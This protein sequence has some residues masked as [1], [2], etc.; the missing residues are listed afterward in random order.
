MKE[1]I[2]KLIKTIHDVAPKDR[3]VK[4]MNVCGSHEHTIT[5]SGMRSLM[6]ETIEL[7]PGPGCP[8]CVCSESDIVNAINL[9]KRED[10]ILATYGDMLRVPTQI[11]S[12]RSSGGNYKM[13][14]APH[15]VLKIAKENPEKNVVFF[16][17][18]FETT[19][20][21]TAALIEM[22]LPKNV[23][24]LTSQKLTP[25]IME[26]L[27]KDSEVGV[28]AF[29]APGHVSAIVG[30]DAWKIFPKK[31]GIPTV[32]AGFEPENLLLAIL[33]ILLQIKEGKA[34]LENVY[35]GVVK[36][37]GNKKAQELMY[38][39]FEKADVNWRG[40]GY[41]PKSGLEFRK[42]YD[43]INAKKVFN[44]PEIEEKKVAGCICDKIVLGKAYPTECK[45]FGKVCTPRSPKGPCMVSLEGACNIWYRF[46]K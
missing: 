42:E 24:V 29:V 45:L 20:A 4:I 26:V 15:E 25:E 23:T 35:R 33:K 40:I 10:T 7:V 2:E 6:P 18:G 44:L 19:T 41:I 9:S 12:I 17:I 13:V 11:G 32:V 31:Y 21:P 27:V 43:H 36:Q 39:Y 34:E 46:G 3:K 14:S 22:G 16:S 5:Y 1:K 30:A 38:K 28:D 8:V 37:E